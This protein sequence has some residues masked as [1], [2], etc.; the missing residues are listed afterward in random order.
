MLSI[1]HV[2]RDRGVGGPTRNFVGGPEDVPPLRVSPA[3]QT[4]HGVQLLL[5]LPLNVDI[6]RIRPIVHALENLDPRVE[7]NMEFSVLFYAHTNTDLTVV[8]EIHGHLE[9]GEEH[10][11]GGGGDHEVGGGREG[12][13]LL[14]LHS[15]RSLQ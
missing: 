13:L 6:T 7:L 2:R 9:D 5:H 3:V 4:L 11:A 15:N 8:Q 12:G 10:G 14:R 1:Q